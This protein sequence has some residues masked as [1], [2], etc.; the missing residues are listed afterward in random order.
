MPNRN[1]DDNVSNNELERSLGRIEG[2]LDSL[3]DAVLEHVRDDK[4]AF[5]ELKT[6]VS[7]MEKKMYTF[8]GA[9]GLIIGIFQYY[10]V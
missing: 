2:K 4:E 5:S 1:P 10:K 6:R 3:A 7:I 9:V 8:L